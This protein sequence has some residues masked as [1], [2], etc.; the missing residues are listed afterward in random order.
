[1]DWN[2]ADLFE[3]VADT[4]PDRVALA[5]GVDG[6]TRTWRDFDRN[7]NALALHL[8]RGHRPVDK[9]ALYAY[10]RPEFV[11]ALSGALKARMVPVNVNYRYR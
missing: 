1:M 3:L 6:P 11:E 8:A 5:H 7:A 2:L 9:L 4:A 10:N